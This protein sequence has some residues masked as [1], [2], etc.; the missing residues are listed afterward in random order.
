M[1]VS[2]T[3]LV[4]NDHVPRTAWY[5]LAKSRELKHAPIARTLFGTP[6][7]LFR[8]EN[9]RAGALVDR[10]PHRN[11]PLSQGCV[12]RGAVECPYHGW[13]FDTQ[14][15]CVEVPGLHPSRALPK[16]RVG[17][18]A[19]IERGGWIWVFGTPGTEPDTEPFEFP[20]V[21]DPRYT[22]VPETIEAEGTVRDVA[23]NALDVPHT[24]FLHR[25]LFRTAKV[26]NDIEVVVRRGKDRVEA[27]YIGEPRP[28]GI[29]GRLLAPQG[30]EVIHFDR[31]IAPAI[32]QVEYRLG[33]DA[34]LVATTVLTP[35]AATKT[36]IAAEVAFRL[37]VKVPTSVFVPILKPI[38]LQILGQDLRMLKTIREHAEAFGGLRYAST[39]LDVLGPHIDALLSGNDVD[40]A[41]LGEVAR[42]RMHV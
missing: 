13:R 8:D 30:G 9:G 40:S 35:L 21:D 27:E 16:F 31:F 6:L 14:G 12:E 7:V 5:I 32:A 15:R 39:E 2:N 10:C 4:T 23:E 19:V 36:L 29:I 24:A 25:G 33:G 3:P 38:A 41:S 1:S 17:S 34:H 28:S 42:I 37:P 18:H 26:R 22:R 11:A 20:F